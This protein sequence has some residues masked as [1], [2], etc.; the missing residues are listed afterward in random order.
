[1]LVQELLGQGTLNSEFQAIVDLTNSRVHGYE[2]LIRGPADT[3]LHQPVALFAAAHKAGCSAALEVSALS[4]H[5]RRFARANKASRLFVNLSPDPLLKGE[6]DAVRLLELVKSAGLNPR[7]VVVELTE[8]CRVE[9]FDRLLAAVHDLRRAGFDMALDDLGSGYS[10]LRQWSELKP[11]YV[12][13]DRHFVHE[14]HQDAG[15]REFVHAIVEIGRTLG[16]QVIAEG[17]ET[18]EEFEVVR[19][20]GVPYAQGFWFCRPARI[21]PP[22]NPE[23]VTSDPATRP[24]F[25]TTQTVGSIVKR[26]EDIDTSTLVNQAL[27]RFEER[28][29]LRCL[30][31]TEHGRPVG[32][33]TR[34][35]LMSLYASRY[36][37]DLFGRR[38]VSEIMLHDFVQVSVEATLDEISERITRDYNEVPEQDL[39]VTDVDGTFLGTVSFLQL[40]KAITQLQVRSARYANPLT[41]LPG[42]VP[43]NERIDHLLLKGETFHVAYADVDNFKPYNDVYGYALGDDVIRTLGRILAEEAATT[44]LVGHIGGDDFILVM[45]SE[46]WDVRCRRMLR[47]FA[48][49]TPRFYRAEDREA[50]GIQSVDRR[51]NVTF[52]PFLSLSVGITEVTPYAHGSHQEVASIASEVKHQAKRQPGNSLFVDRRHTDSP[53]AAGTVCDEV[54]NR[55][56]VDRNFGQ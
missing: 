28:R 53:P 39:L 41:Q 29:D 32:M 17:V 26:S 20:L 44:D 11:E 27:E 52:F 6:I 16:S 2:A 14:L 1:M 48:D 45:L 7:Q 47:R 24:R 46:D 38:R 49:E 22:I 43:I 55:A 4:L 10:G 35:Q 51:G 5:L 8:N 33:V 50:G 19:A 31:V 23:A 54:I 37:R 3:P 34:Q 21:P 18:R 15:K 9:R 12:K 40:L 30:A 13:I 36:G 42:S 56:A 25:S